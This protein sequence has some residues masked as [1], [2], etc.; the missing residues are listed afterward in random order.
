MLSFFV[1]TERH[2]LPTKADKDTNR[3]EYVGLARNRRT[4]KRCYIAENWY[5]KKRATRRAGKKNKSHKKR[6]EPYSLT[7]ID[8]LGTRMKGTKRT[9]R[10]VR[11]EQSEGLK[12]KKR[13]TT[14]GQQRDN[15]SD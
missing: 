13:K 2:R 14:I 10:R 3:N 15:I 9:K 11:K 8:C 4:A 5:T 12:K 1:P 7:S 6:Q